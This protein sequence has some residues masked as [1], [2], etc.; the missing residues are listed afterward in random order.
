MT[1]FALMGLGAPTTSQSPHTALAFTRAAVAAGHRIVRVF[2]FHDGVHCGSDLAVPVAGQQNVAAQ[3]A[4][5][6]QQHGIDLVVCVASALKRGILNH[7]E[8]KRYAKNASN[9]HPQFDLS[10]LG[11][12]VEACA[13][14]DRVMTFGA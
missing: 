13:V 2:F 4:E 11:Q 9:L 8:A 6:A 10:G 14:A 5:L 3:W 12:W 1:T 7:S